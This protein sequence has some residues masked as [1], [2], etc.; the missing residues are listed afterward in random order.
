MAVSTPTNLKKHLIAQGFEVYRTLAD[1]I[2][3][4]ERVR[5]NLIMDAGVAAVFEPALAV[6]FFVRAQS[7][8]FR[9][10]SEEQLFAR[11][12]AQAHESLQRGYLEV[13]TRIVPV[14]D[15][16]DNSRTLDTWYEVAVER[17]AADLEGLFA[18]L[19]YALSVEKTAG[20]GPHR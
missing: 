14:S 3:L 8:D 20:S 13:E 10:E 15:P 16:G 9:G 7:N 4:A 12:R 6:R 5:D 19:R 18:E 17:A 11:A 2:M 1:Q